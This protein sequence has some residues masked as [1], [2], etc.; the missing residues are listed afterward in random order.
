M[1]DYKNKPEHN[2]FGLYVFVQTRDSSLDRGVLFQ[3]GV[4]LVL[5]ITMNPNWHLG[6]LHARRLFLRELGM[7]LTNDQNASERFTRLIQYTTHCSVLYVHCVQK[8]SEPPNILQ[9]HE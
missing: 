2:F 3:S 1:A 5:W 9:Y 8:K 4:V 7:S 6:K